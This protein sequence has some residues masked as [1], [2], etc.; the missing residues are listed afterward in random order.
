MYA[1]VVGCLFF[2]FCRLLLLFFCFPPVAC[3]SQ[4]VWENSLITGKLGSLQVKI[5]GDELSFLASGQVG[6]LHPL[7]MEMNNNGLARITIKHD[8]IILQPQTAPEWVV[9]TP[10]VVISPTS[11][12][13]RAADQSPFIQ[14][15]NLQT[16]DYLST[17]IK[18]IRNPVTTYQEPE[19][20]APPRHWASIYQFADNTW[21]SANPLVAPTPTGKT[22]NDI[23]PTCT[24]LEFVTG[25]LQGTIRE[26]IKV[27]TRTDAS[28]VT[29]NTFD[30]GRKVTATRS[31]QR[32]TTSDNPW[33]STSE[34][35]Q[36]E[37]M[38]VA[39]PTPTAEV[40]QGIKRKRQE[41][42][43]DTG[44]VNKKSKPGF[45]EIS[46]QAII[47]SIVGHLSPRDL[48][49]LRKTSKTLCLSIHS[50]IVKTS[51]GRHAYYYFR[52]LADTPVKLQVKYC[53]ML[54]RV[55]GLPMKNVRSQPPL[56]FGFMLSYFPENGECDPY[57]FF[58]DFLNSCSVDQVL[59][60]LYRMSQP[61]ANRYA[62]YF[63]HYMAHNRK[64]YRLISE[65][66][67][68]C[69]LS[70]S[71]LGQVVFMYSND[72][73]WQI[74]RLLVRRVHQLFNQKLSSF[75]LNDLALLMKAHKSDVAAEMIKEVLS[76]ILSAD[77]SQL[78]AMALADLVMIIEGAA[79]YIEIPDA[80]KLLIRIANIIIADPPMETE[81]GPQIADSLPFLTAASLPELSRIANKFNQCLRSENEELN[82]LARVVLSAIAHE[83]CSYPDLHQWSYPYMSLAANAF[84]EHLDCA[85]VSE[86]LG[87]ITHHVGQFPPL[88]SNIHTLYCLARGISQQPQADEDKSEASCAMVE[89]AR[90]VAGLKKLGK[91]NKPHTLMIPHVLTR[92]I[93]KPAGRRAAIKLAKYFV[94]KSKGKVGN[95]QI[96]HLALFVNS[97]GKIN[98]PEVNIHKVFKQI[99]NGYILTERFS[100]HF[101]LQT[102]A[103]FLNRYSHYMA[104]YPAYA[105]TPLRI[106]VQDLLETI[107][108]WGSL[109]GAPPLAL[110][111][112]AYGA[113]LFDYGTSDEVIN[114]VIQEINRTRLANASVRSTIKLLIPV[115][116]APFSHERSEALKI[117]C[118]KIPSEELSRLSPGILKALEDGLELCFPSS[119]FDLKGRIKDELRKS[120]SSSLGGINTTATN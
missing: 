119:V 35:S 54:S 19:V 85:G 34:S 10:P 112:I 9:Y 18:T 115:S 62:R 118:E 77:H 60:I 24:E 114:M 117:I 70:G 37:S 99:A 39:T 102:L 12:G 41:E 61:P 87:K 95:M 2:S 94:K 96:K 66:G 1:L 107:S 17:I 82:D 69:Q 109:T 75:P 46:T 43:D 6:D 120:A 3:G 33:D 52:E 86:A 7:H 45:G 28:D 53:A 110:S 38:T 29:T 90:S 76:V 49:A 88:D 105:K 16:T 51:L 11:T 32:E 57:C 4:A 98:N 22:V 30:Y 64:K 108:N 106:F 42:T 23:S 27:Y 56:I 20:S 8:R 47:N 44:S 40:R 97:L 81:S 74:S 80:Q 5:R 104:N 84:G 78:S 15:I 103:L 116:K 36:T 25:T 55:V 26:R 68:L 13:C 101:S 65:Y 59:P 93:N 63:L 113:S 79:T 111:Q 58:Q 92:V 67:I 72:E 71:Q 21:Y 100:E 31:G 73:R 50:H 83:V 91:I 14:L 89:I 48:M